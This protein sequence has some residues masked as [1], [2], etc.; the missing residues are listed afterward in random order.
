MKVYWLRYLGWFAALKDREKKIVTVAVLIGGLFLGFTYGI[1]PGL[2]A[3]GRDTRAATE[4]NAIVVQITQQLAVLQGG[5]QDPDAALRA[6]LDD[7]RNNINAQDARFVVLQERLVP[8][9]NMTRLLESLL[10][11]SGTLQLLSLRTLPAVPVIERKPAAATRGEP[12][13]GPGSATA[14]GQAGKSA[15]DLDPKKA[16]NIFRHGMEI[17][18]AGSY[19]DLLAYVTALE[20]A[21]QRVIWDKLELVA[22]YPKSQLTLTVST[23]SLEK[24]WLML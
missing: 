1:E 19:G 6:Q 8:P 24:S 9:A 5:A 12:S 22:E 18:L 16:P 2:L 3:S 23:L 17:T 13:A 4:A 15:S 10:A 14:N 11:R 21:P 7:L 20:S